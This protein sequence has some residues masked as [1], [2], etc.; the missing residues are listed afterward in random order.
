MVKIW[1]LTDEF[2]DYKA[3]VQRILS[4]TQNSNFLQL[5]ILM[6]LPPAS[7]VKRI[8]T[9]NL[10]AVMKHRLHHGATR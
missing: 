8:L 6:H 5:S 4:D 1:K 10:F 3:M 2:I 7:F 9:T